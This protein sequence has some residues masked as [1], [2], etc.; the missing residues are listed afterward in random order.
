MLLENKI[1]KPLFKEIGNYSE[2]TI[3]G[4]E[5]QTPIKKFKSKYGGA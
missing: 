4:L 1:K 2:L 3:N 5:I